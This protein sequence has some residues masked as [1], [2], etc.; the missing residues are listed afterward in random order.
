MR[1]TTS[2][3]LAILPGGA[4]APEGLLRNSDRGRP[5]APLAEPQGEN[6]RKPET[7]A[8]RLCSAAVAERAKA[9]TLVIGAGAVDRAVVVVQQQR[10]QSDAREAVV[11]LVD[12]GVPAGVRAR[13]GR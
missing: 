8:S 7:T 1:G 4:E 11:V 12:Q 13:A 5:T 10:G 2:M 6:G 9:V 3:S